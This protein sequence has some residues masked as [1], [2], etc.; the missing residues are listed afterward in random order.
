MLG[1][2]SLIT[3]IRAEWPV[4]TGPAPQKAEWGIAYNIPLVV[5]RGEVGRER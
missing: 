2:N 3:G 1:C 5:N 4:V